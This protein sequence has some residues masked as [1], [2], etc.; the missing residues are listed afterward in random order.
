MKRIY[1]IYYTPK[2]IVSEY[3]FMLRISENC[4]RKIFKDDMIF[5][6]CNDLTAEQLYNKIFVNPDERS[7]SLI[8]EITHYY[9]S[10][11][12]EISDWL[13]EK[14]HEVDTYNKSNK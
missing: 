3:K 13:K 4:A 5:A 12:Y 6:M 14:M 2:L 10:L 9:G 11:P 8:T 7:G 1:L